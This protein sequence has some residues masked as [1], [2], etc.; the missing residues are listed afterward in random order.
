MK[1]IWKAL[2]RGILLKIEIDVIQIP[3]KAGFFI[4]YHPTNSHPIAI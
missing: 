1:M 3:A 4:F 2:G